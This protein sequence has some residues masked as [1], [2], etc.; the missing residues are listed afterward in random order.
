MQHNSTDVS[1][2]LL[3]YHN[4]LYKPTQQA[5]DILS[6]SELEKFNRCISKRQK[7]YLLGRLL[8]RRALQHTLNTH[9]PKIDVIDQDGLPPLVALAEQNHI[10][11]SISHSY[12]LIAIAMLR[13]VD[14]NAPKI[15][16]DVELI[17]PVN[18]FET[19]R[20]FCNNSQ[21]NALDQLN[22]QQQKT[23]LY[24][25]YWTLKEAYL[26]AYHK[27]IGDEQFKRLGFK[28]S[29]SS[30]SRKLV[31]S[32]FY[33][34]DKSLSERYQIASYCS[35][36]HTIKTCLITGHGEDIQPFITVQ[37]DWDNFTIEES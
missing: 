29:P 12:N 15:G 25:L 35:A 8:L 16:L 10:R 30:E 33:H 7:E 4:V 28:T 3:P 26:K 31:S 32:Y 6:D 20:F 2:W 17:K 23:D 27:G 14:Q 18:S 22:C 13:G 34:P 11:F 5:I 9:L 21:Q 1:L 19:T 37:T 36:P 24:Y